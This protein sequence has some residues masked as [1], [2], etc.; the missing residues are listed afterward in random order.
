MLLDNHCG[1]D[2]NPSKA[3]KVRTGCVSK[4][5]KKFYFGKLVGNSCEIRTL[6]ILLSSWK[7]KKQFRDTDVHRV[8]ALHCFSVNISS[9]FV[10]V[11][12]CVCFR[13]KLCHMRADKVIL[14]CLI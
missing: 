13:T 14:T 8:T 11:Y 1:A 3:S 6:N 2:A 7:Q 5:V 10:G 4:F 9:P 12:V